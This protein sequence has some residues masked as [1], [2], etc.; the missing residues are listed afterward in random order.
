VLATS[1][2]LLRVRFEHLYVLHPLGV[3]DPADVACMDA[4]PAAP[5]VALFLDRARAVDASFALSDANAST[6]AALCTRLDGL[7]LALELASA[8]TRSLPPTL[9]LAHLDQW[10]DLLAGA[11]DARGPP[12][13][14]GQ[15]V[16]RRARG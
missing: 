1:R 6:I 12:A 5:A 8:R 4:V 9:L 2:E 3:P 16:D 11:R 14:H 7:P 10:L 13:V 15:P